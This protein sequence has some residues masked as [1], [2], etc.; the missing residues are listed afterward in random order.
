MQ[1]GTQVV[2]DGGSVGRA[3]DAVRVLGA[4][5][6]ELVA[7]EDLAGPERLQVARR[8]AHHAH[9]ELARVVEVGLDQGGV[10]VGERLVERATGVLRV[11]GVVN[12]RN[13]DR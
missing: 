13:T 5:V 2:A 10:A 7:R 1:P 11:I 6:V 12:D 8:V 9:F 4:V 3:R